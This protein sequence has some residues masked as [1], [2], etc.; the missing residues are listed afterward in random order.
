MDQVPID[1]QQCS[2]VFFAAHYVCVPDF[3]VK[4]FSSHSSPLIDEFG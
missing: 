4:R 1:V 3:V 2:A